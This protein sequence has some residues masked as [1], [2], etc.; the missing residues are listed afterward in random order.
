M[1]YRGI[2][3]V[4]ALLLSVSVPLQAQSIV[5]QVVDAHS[6]IGLS[7]G[8]VVLVGL[9]LREISRTVTDSQGRY[10]V[11]TGRPGTFYLSFERP[12]L[13][14]KLSGPV[15][16]VGSE[17]YDQHLESLGGLRRVRQ[18]RD[19]LLLV[20]LLPSRGQRLRAVRQ[21]RQLG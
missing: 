17:L 21:P 19:V 20:V 8:T 13:A 3:L 14:S 12:G 1:R 6:G 10:V 16:L 9:D 18:R 7:S 2:P 5:G 11:A 4:L 15:R